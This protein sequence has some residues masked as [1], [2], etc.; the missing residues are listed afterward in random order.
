MVLLVSQS[1]DL[2]VVDGQVP[3]VGLAQLVAAAAEQSLTL[4][5][6]GLQGGQHCPA[7]LGTARLTGQVHCAAVVQV[8]NRTLVETGRR[9]AVW[10]VSTLT[11]T[12]FQKVWSQNSGCVVMT[13]GAHE[14]QVKHETVQ[15]KGGQGETVCSFTSHSVS[16]PRLPLNVDDDD[17]D[18]TRSLCVSFSRC[19]VASYLCVFRLT[20][21]PGQTCSVHVLHVRVE[22][23][24]APPSS[25]YLCQQVLGFPSQSVRELPAPRRQVQ[26]GRG[27]H[28]GRLHVVGVVEAAL[29]AGAAGAAPSS[30]SSTSAAAASPTAQA[31]AAAGSV[32]A[33]G[34]AGWAGCLAVALRCGDEHTLGWLD[35]RWCLAQ[36]VQQMD[37]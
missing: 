17:D 21:P 13:M 31:A 27:R 14:S 30:S 2:G 20:P 23:D 24:G 34:A 9:K 8:A 15:I 12:T 36:T 25:H 16:T 19:L 6:H 5:R 4:G 26:D 28:V 7:A 22:P 18:V 3:A 29:T 33:G 37:R 35:S 32:A 10:C 11:C 1:F